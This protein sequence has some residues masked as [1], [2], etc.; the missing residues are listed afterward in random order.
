MK[1]IVGS[2]LVVASFL[3]AFTSMAAAEQVVQGTGVGGTLR[4]T[5]LDQTE[6]ALIIAQVTVVDSTGATFTVAVD[7]RGIAV[8]QNL[9][10]GVYQIT[11]TAESFRPI[12]TPF[13]VRRGE[14][15]T[16]LRLAVAT[17]E[18]T[19]VVQDQ[20]AADRRD[21]GFT[22]TL[23]QD[24]IDALPDDPDEMADELARMAG[25]GAQ[26]FVDGFRGGRMPPKD[27]IQQIRFHT[28]SFSAEYHEAG[29][30]RV[31]VI[32][33]PGM[34]G[35][36]GSS[37]FGF[38]DESLNA[39][40]AFADEK[41]P[42]QMRRYMVNFSGPLAKGRTGLSLSFDGNSSYD[43]RTIVAQS[44]NSGTVNSLAVSPTDAINFS[45][46]VEHL[47]GGSAQVRAEYARRQNE[48]SNL[49][50]GDFDLPE[51]AY[52]TEMNTDTFRLRTTNVIGKKV[53]SEFRVEFNNSSNATLPGS[54][55]PTIRVNDAFT[56]GGA[57][58]SGIRNAREL[59]LA[60]N[61]DFTVARKHS[62]RVGVLLEAGWWDSTQR[63]NGN[64][65]YTF[66]NTDA[67]NA[68]TPT[69]Y[70]I[71][72]GD[73]LVEYSQTKAGWFVQDDFRP[74]RTLQLS[75]GLRQEIQTQ[76]D[77]RFNLAP[78]AAFTWNATK[79]ATVRGGYGIFYDWYESNLYEQTIRVD[80]EHQV[81]VIVQ[82]PG[83]PFIEGGGTRLPASV[84]R[85]ASLGQP[86]IHQA[87][88]GFERPLTSWADMRADYM[89]T[90]GYDTLRS[91]NV[92]APING[93]RPDPTVGNITEIQSSGK[94][95]SD[96]ATV[97]LNMR[98]APRRILGMVMYQLGNSRNFAD[99]ATSIPSDS[100]NPDLDWGPSA[101][102]VR[103]RIFF[104]F[105]S[106]IGRGVRLSLGMQGSSALPYNI[107]TGFDT[108]GDTV[109]NDRPDG[110]ERN[111]ARGASQWTANVRLNKSIGLGGAR[112]GAPGGRGARPPPPPPAGGVAAQRG[113]GGP[114]PGGGG[115]GPQI[116]VMEGG[117]QKYRLDVYLNIQNA[118]NH[119]NYNAFIGNQQS[120]F[121]GTP[122]SAG[123]ARR[124]EIGASFGF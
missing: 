65:T 6:A 122:T 97:A 84:I 37:N 90:R 69:N 119:V 124:I 77:A 28:N 20:S 52:A 38:R 1:R 15:R 55:Q 108:N 115:D 114:G 31:E 116:M 76:V 110:V 107:T 13:T 67:F 96:R 40:N 83:F 30:V 9:N 51:R 17:I 103:H 75:F 111:S 23:T 11:A 44:P 72:V 7:D 123:P 12:A 18:Q 4:V 101:Q 19:V 89:F 53:F 35:W 47:I 50:V 62:M 59:E 112:P 66:T 95:A 3:F 68:G 79:K 91:I 27:Q 49:G 86:I 92:N 24:E 118:F 70:V 39:T 2:I 109:F 48:R 78:R 32:T 26:I 54:L 73:P 29:M 74:S 36:R 82:N 56:A 113:P 43:S 98:Y 61:F 8:F 57:G 106:P 34:G 121:F 105:N 88:I 80:G 102:D 71:R 25:P 93:V 14:N 58:Q 45:A 87:S 85:S 33:K 99:G 10:P 81:D 63:S 22:Q 64:G 117:N 41:G 60:Q 5:V 46:R 21:N 16:T 42:E 100:L 94:R 104:N 120:S